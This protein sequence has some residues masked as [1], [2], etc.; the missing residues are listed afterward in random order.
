MST[1]LLYVPEVQDAGAD[2]STP[3]MVEFMTCAKSIAPHTLQVHICLCE[4][5]P[6][7]TKREIIDV[8]KG[9]VEGGRGTSIKFWH[10]RLLVRVDPLDSAHR[11]FSKVWIPSYI[12]N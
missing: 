1:L 11:K 3:K 4:L 10:F 2:L 7:E 12:T 5:D 9:R 6:I 8:G